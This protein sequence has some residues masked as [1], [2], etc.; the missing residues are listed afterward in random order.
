LKYWK[1]YINP[2]IDVELYKSLLPF[3]KITE[4]EYFQKYKGMGHVALTSPPYFNKEIYS[5]DDGQACHMYDSYEGWRDGFLYMTFK[6]TYD[7]LRKGGL[8]WFNV[9]DIKTNKGKNEFLPIESDS[10]KI[11]ESFGFKHIDTYKMAMALMAGRDTGDRN[12]GAKPQD[13]LKMGKLLKNIVK[14]SGREY[15][16]KYGREYY[17]KYEP[18]FLFEKE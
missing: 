11:A 10:I 17:Q 13:S 14:L 2:N 18:I 3:E 6:N 15:Y 9:A 4:F 16:Q 1:K 5:D 12:K 7:F 8:F